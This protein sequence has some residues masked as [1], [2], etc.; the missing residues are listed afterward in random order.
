[1]KIFA[2]DTSSEAASAALIDDNV[3]LGEYILNHKKTHSQKLMP[4]IDEVFT[5]CGLTPNDIDI[6]AVSVGP[7][8]FTGL[9]IGVSTVK[10]LAHASEKPV[11]GISTLEAL[12]Y[13]MP[14]CR[15]TLCTMLDARNE[16]VYNAAYRWNGM[17]IE[18]IEKPN[19]AHISECISR[20]K[21]KDDYIMFTGNGIRA[22]RAFI[23]AELSDKALFS[24]QAYNEV[25]A[26]AVAQAAYFKA[27][28]DNNIK[29][30]IDILPV[31][32]RKSQAEREYE[33]RNGKQ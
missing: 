9:R 10:A 33:E 5:S 27:Y 13:N 26:A 15:Y 14:F 17:N 24:P 7:G 28:D 22:N 25:S 32:L 20:I 2:V 16:Q 3:L 11:I 23:E 8:S 21:D 12:A 4:I 31:Y 1:M 18:V 19:A 30:C 6:Y 29:S